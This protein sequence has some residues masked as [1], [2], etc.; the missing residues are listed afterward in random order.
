MGAVLLR[1]PLGFSL[2]EKTM[3]QAYSTSQEGIDTTDG[4]LAKAQGVTHVSYRQVNEAGL[5]Y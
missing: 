4:C 3:T 2:P 5:R 1:A